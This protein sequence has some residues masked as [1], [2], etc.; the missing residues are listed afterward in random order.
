[1]L[2]RAP[3]GTRDI[4]PN[5]TPI[6]RKLENILHNICSIYG[7]KEIRTP[8]F[9]HTELFSRSV[10]DTTD[11]V[12]KEMYTFEDKSGRSITLRPEGTA[13]VVRSFIENGMSSEPMPVKLYYMITAYRYENVQKGRYR[14]FHQFG[15]EAF[16]AEGPGID[17]EIIGMLSHIFMETGIKKIKLNINSIGCPACRTTYNETLKK[18]AKTRENM[19]CSDCANRIERNPMR[20]LDCKEES[21]REIMNDAPVLID[22]ICKDCL[23]HFEGLKKELTSMAIPFNVDKAIVR[24]L[25]YYTRTVFEFVSDSIGA[26]GTVCGGGRYDGLVEMCGG[27]PIAGIGFGLGIE[28][29]LLQM[30]SEESEITA[31][32]KN[33]LFIA[34][35]GKDIDEY[36]ANI[37]FTLRKKGLPV[38]RELTGRSLKAQ[39]KYAGKSCSKYVLVLGDEEIASGKA[40][41]RNMQTGTTSDIYLNT[42]SILKE[43]LE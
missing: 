9:E 20:L 30:K 42:D 27:S 37:T 14:E 13:S 24:G 7:Y 22:Y 34:T 36:A 16:G 41:L 31:S 4:L 26:Q 43:I 6:W 10:G 3:K 29:L 28:R 40:K 35:T 17:A 39:M 38:E 19:L 25:D 23:D 15:A 18:F 12:Q 8:V 1:M 21:C 2:T 32:E 11:I 5:E 33:R